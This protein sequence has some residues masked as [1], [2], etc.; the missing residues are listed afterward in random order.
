MSRVNDVSN[1]YIICCLLLYICRDALARLPSLKPSLLLIFEAMASTHQPEF[2]H[3]LSLD[4]HSQLIP[5]SGLAEALKALFIKD[6]KYWDQRLDNFLFCEEEGHSQ[7]KVMIVDLEQITF[8]D[9][10][11]PWEE[12]PRTWEKSMNFG[13][14]C[15][16]MRTFRQIRQSPFLSDCTGEFP[17]D[18]AYENM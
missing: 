5:Q 17:Y 6:A 11:P 16:L 7:N 3:N 13:T 9:Q 12:F 2:T 18:N 4:S 15:S 1:A 10:A 8:P 14:S